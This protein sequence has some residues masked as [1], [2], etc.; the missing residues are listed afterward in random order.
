MPHEA[1]DPV[2]HAY[3]T[4]NQNALIPFLE[5]FLGEKITETTALYDLI[6]GKTATRDIEVKSRTLNYF[7]TDPFI[8]RDGWLMPACKIQHAKRSGRPLLFFYNWK[9][10]DSVW[11]F[12]YSPEA[13]KGLKPFVPHWKKDGQLH[14][15]IPQNRWTCIRP[16]KFVD[17]E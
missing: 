11:V 6:D 9:R 12:E 17:L 1:F 15:N 2:S 4:A 5:S 14:Y 16:G 7:Y 13:M 8:Q 3:G 10:D